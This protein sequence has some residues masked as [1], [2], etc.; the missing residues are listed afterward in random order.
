M[1]SPPTVSKTELYNLAVILWVRV[2][3][4]MF[5]IILKCKSLDLRFL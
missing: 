1:L 4:T 5:F 2:D 3:K